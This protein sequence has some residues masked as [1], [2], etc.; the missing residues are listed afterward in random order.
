MLLSDI[1]LD[2]FYIYVASTGDIATGTIT[3]E[4]RYC[5]A[6]SYYCSEYFFITQGYQGSIGG[7]SGV[8]CL[9]HPYNQRKD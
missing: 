1:T 4:K 8:Y 6:S 7:D 9:C 2:K 3:V 5:T